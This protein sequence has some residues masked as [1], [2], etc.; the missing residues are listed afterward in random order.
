[1]TIGV[2]KKAMDM[3]EKEEKNEEIKLFFLSQY[4][5]TR[6]INKNPV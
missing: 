3:H 1:V 6:S 2:E 5:E 4:D